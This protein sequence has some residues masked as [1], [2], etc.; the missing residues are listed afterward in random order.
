ME[1]VII[2]NE[3]DIKIRRAL[4]ILNSIIGESERKGNGNLKSL[5]SLVTGEML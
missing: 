2:K 1:F 5:V 3:G 4:N